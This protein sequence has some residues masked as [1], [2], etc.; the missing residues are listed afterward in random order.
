MGERK[1]LLLRMLKHRMLETE[2][3]DTKGRMREK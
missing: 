2:E 1:T 3:K